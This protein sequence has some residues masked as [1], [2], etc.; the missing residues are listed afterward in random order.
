MFTYRNTWLLFLIPSGMVGC[1][2]T[3]SGLWGV[4]FLTTVYG[5]SPALSASLTSLLLVAWALGGPFFGW[6]SD[7][8]QNR[9]RLYLIGCG[10]SVAGWVVIALIENIPMNILVPILVVTGFASGSMIVSFAFAKESVPL[11]LSGTVSGTINMS[12]MSGPMILQ[13]TVGFVLDKMWKGDLIDGVRVYDA[14]AY[15][16]GFSIMVA[17]IV[18]S[19]ILLFFTRETNCQQIAE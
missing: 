18:I 12:V 2:L 3:L 1:V 6:L 4:P 19:F 11:R 17:W 15:H 10:I 7:Q 13:P 5:L 14:A 9:K 16:I 8:L